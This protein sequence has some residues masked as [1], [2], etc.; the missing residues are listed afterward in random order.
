MIIAAHQAS[1]SS[2]AGMGSSN[3]GSGQKGARP[4]KGFWVVVEL[5]QRTQGVLVLGELHKAH[6]TR[7]ASTASLPLGILPQQLDLLDLGACLAGTLFDL[8][9][10]GLA[11]A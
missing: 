9:H 11:S 7:L 3:A 1:F 2:R 8:H 5:P 4:T 10:V 6:A